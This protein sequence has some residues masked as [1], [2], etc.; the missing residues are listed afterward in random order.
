ME[1]SK[2]KKIGCLSVIG[3][4]VLLG[5]I[6]LIVDSIDSKKSKNNSVKIE[7][8]I[9]QGDF[10]EA[11]KLAKTSEY[12]GER[13]MEKVVKAQVSSLLDRGDFSLASDVAK[14][15]NRYSTYF[16]LLLERMVPLYESNKQGLFM[17]LAQLNIPSVGGSRKNWDDEGHYT[18]SESTV[19]S[20]Y[21]SFN[22]SLSQLMVYAKANDDMEYVKKV[23]KLLKPLYKTKKGK[24]KEWDVKKQENVEVDGMV[25]EDT[26]TD[27]TQANQIK[28]ELGLK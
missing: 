13:M 4:F 1:I 8:L 10:I 17:A 28:K 27:Y 26:P 5:I 6:G 22:N 14:E 9:E 2:T 21:S 25:W 3:F 19:N 20:L 24:V 16:D 23:S 12:G 15:E 18:M 7:D 11:K